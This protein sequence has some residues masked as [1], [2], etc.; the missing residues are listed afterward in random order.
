MRRI[1]LPFSMCLLCSLSVA[2][3]NLAYAFTYSKPGSVTGTSIKLVDLHTGQAVRSVYED[4]Y[5]YK[6]SE[7]SHS[8][9]ISSNDPVLGKDSFLLP[10]ATSVAAAAFDGM[11]DRL[12][13]TPLGI[14]QL[15]YI[16]V[17]K[18]QSP[19]FNYVT[20]HEFGVCKGIFDVPGQITRMVV[21]PGGVGYA[22]TNDGDHLIQFTTGSNIAI[23]DLGELADDPGNKMISVHS[24]CSSSGGDLVSSVSG[25]LVLVTAQSQVFSIDVHTRVATYRGVITGLPAGFTSNGAAVDDEGSLIVCSANANPGNAY[26]RVDMISLK[27]TAVSGSASVLLAADL[28]NGNLL[29][30]S[31]GASKQLSAD[32]SD[33]GR[34]FSVYPS[35]VTENYLNISLTNFEKGS[36]DVQI[37]DLTGR[38]IKKWSIDVNRYW[39]VEKVDIAASTAQGVYVIRLSDKAGSVVYIRQI[40]VTAD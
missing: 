4:A 37:Q 23:T 29:G 34:I 39:Q 16:D 8:Q 3:Q 33:P 10:M 32:R 15:R 5:F 18:G 31:A 2:G 6:I 30:Q 21:G 12:F 1:A 20:G 22:L 26:F 35:P 27:A 25:E 28:A 36:Y 40:V 17:G 11:H 24:L 13:Y 7:A 9:M 19:V 14:N 38:S